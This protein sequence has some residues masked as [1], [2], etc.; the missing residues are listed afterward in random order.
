MS[1]AYEDNLEAAQQYATEV[2]TYCQLASLDKWRLATQGEANYVLG[3]KEEAL[4]CY[5][6]AI[7]S[8]PE[9]TPRELDSMYQQVIRLTSIFGDEETAYNLQKLFGREEHD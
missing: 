8:K 2:L 3:N 7:E 1:L 4:T 6:A 9:P 5:Q